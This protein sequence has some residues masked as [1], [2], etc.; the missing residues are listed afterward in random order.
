MTGKF[1]P[2]LWYSLYAWY[3][4]SLENGGL[5]YG[6]LSSYG[7]VSAVC[8]ERFTPLTHGTGRPIGRKLPEHDGKHACRECLDI[9]PPTGPAEG[10]TGTRKTPQL[11][12]KELGSWGAQLKWSAVP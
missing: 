10:S 9:A 1:R 7:E 3:A 6:Y 5:H 2:S 12:E 8:G 4:E 11:P